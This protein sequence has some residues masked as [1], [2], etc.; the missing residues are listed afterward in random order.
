ML[1]ILGSSGNKLHSGNI[2]ILRKIRF[3]VYSGEY[4][5]LGTHTAFNW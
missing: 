3:Q 5:F 1:Y 2:S 4:Y